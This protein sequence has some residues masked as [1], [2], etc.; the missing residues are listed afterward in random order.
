MRRSLLVA[1]V[2]LFVLTAQ[3][4]S[5]ATYSNPSTIQIEDAT[6]S[7]PYPSSILVSGAG[8][9][10]RDVNVTLSGYSH[11]F[12]ADV[13][14]LLVG[15]QGQK[16]CLMGHVGGGT[17]IYDITVTLDDESDRV[18]FGALSSGSYQ[19]GPS[20]SCPNFG[21]PAPSGPYSGTLSAFDGTDPNG[22]WRLFVQDFAFADGGQIA[23]G[24]S[25]DIDAVA[26]R[27][28]DGVPD[29]SDNCPA[30]GNA[31]QQDLDGDGV[32]TACDPV[33]LPSTKEQCKGD[34]WRVWHSGTQRFKNRGDCVS[35]VATRGRNGP[36]A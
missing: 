31:D 35:Y 15:P 24:W 32:G 2:A 11:T 19:P 28:G 3:S 34:G 36:A 21:A 30:V 33:E 16:I 18:P 10:V 6:P 17:D 4:A 7:S 5:A 25:L 8:G 9:E 22:T 23:G 29:E 14:I 27:D 1:A 12:P 26:D 20:W 13:A